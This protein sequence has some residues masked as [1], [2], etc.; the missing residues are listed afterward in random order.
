MPESAAYD[1]LTKRYFIS[2]FGD[3]SIIE[4][5]STGGKTYFRKGL[6]KPLGILI[7]ENIL[8]VV[9]NPK[10]V[11][12]FD[13]TDGNIKLDTEIKEAQFINDI[14]SDDSGFLYVTGSSTG[15]IFRIDIASKTYS[16]F[17][18]THGGPN[19]ITYDK[20]K[21]RLLMCYF[22]EKAPIDEINL[23]DSTISRIIT[24]EFTN[25][26]GI[27]LDL[28]GNVY[29]SEWGPGSFETGYTKEGKIYKYDNSFKKGPE[30]ISSIHHG[31]ADIYFNK[32]K[33]E[34]VIPSL[35]S[36]TLEF[37]PLKNK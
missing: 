26:D 14:T 31:P 12:G 29:I 2:N 15:I 30:L 36:D 22:M 25:L 35:L 34:L 20:S 33:N 32:Y 17:M 28:D 1:S 18:K 19:G 9:D 21:N 4:I 11:K 13:I 6:S 16:P 8:Y 5:D 7:Y 23:E 3:G 27:V 24:T 10:S 37:I